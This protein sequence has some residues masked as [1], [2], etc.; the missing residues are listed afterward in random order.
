[1]YLYSVRINTLQ[2]FQLKNLVIWL[3][4]QPLLHLILVPSWNLGTHSNIEPFFLQEPRFNVTNDLLGGRHYNM[5]IITNVYVSDDWH[6][7]FP[8]LFLMNDST[9]N[10]YIMPNLSSQLKLIL[11]VIVKMLRF[12]I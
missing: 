12:M 3:S 4:Y 2:Y 8:F 6:C 7:C 1:M 5:N 11:L 9:H 10:H